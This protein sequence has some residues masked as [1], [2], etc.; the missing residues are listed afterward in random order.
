MESRSVVAFYTKRTPKVEKERDEEGE[1]KSPGTRIAFARCLTNE[2]RFREGRQT[3]EGSQWDYSLFHMSSLLTHPT[4]IFFQFRSSCS[5]VRSKKLALESGNFFLR[6]DGKGRQ[7]G[8]DPCSEQASSYF[9]NFH[10]SSMFDLPSIA[11]LSNP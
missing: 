11:T 6:T 7:I 1:E 4:L 2:Q 9:P 10:G 3:T 8:I 5:Q